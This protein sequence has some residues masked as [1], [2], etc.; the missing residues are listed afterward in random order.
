MIGRKYKKSIVAAGHIEVCEAA[1]VILEAG[2]NAFD[3]MVAAG[4]A[5]TVVEPALTSLGGGGFM[6][7]Y[8]AATKSELFFDFFVDTPGKGHRA[9]ELEPHFFPVT[10]NFS[11]ASQ[12][13]NVGMGSVAVP[14]T[15]KGLLHVHKRLGRMPLKTVIEPARKLA[16]GHELNSQQAHFLDLL[17]PIMTL[18]PAGR[19]LYESNGKY[20]QGGEQL[21]NSSLADFLESIV[22]EG[23][24][25]FYR[26]D[27]AQAIAEDM[28]N[29]DGLL[30]CD[31]LADYQVYERS[32]LKIHYRGAEFLTAPEPSVGGTLIGLS[33]SLAAESVVN[34]PDWGSAEYLKKV[35]ARMQEVER[36]REQGVTTPAALREYF[37]ASDISDRADSPRLFSRGTTHISIADC[38]GNCASMTCSNGEGSGYF[39]PGTGIMLN[40]MMG[41]D[42]LHPEGF[43][44]SPP[45]QRVQSMMSPSMLKKNE[46][47][48]L[49][50]GSGGSKRIRTAITQVLNQIVIDKRDVVDAVEAPRLYWDEDCLQVEPGF[51]DDAISELQKKEKVH[52]WKNKDVYFGGVHCVVPGIK[53]AG[54][55]RRGGA[56]LEV[57]NPT[58]RVE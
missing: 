28:R 35:T 5:S 7:G 30:T 38:N 48:E 42:D 11:G 43:H 8:S 6:L 34:E 10:V 54:D 1:S 40:N 55:S 18:M 4:F 51:T 53:G 31:D 26:G 50:I 49:V 41:E 12:D 44:S 20:V 36:L 2:G 23:D 57:K 45:G 37:A 21:V 25:S 47:I 14:G 52:I 39:A 27:I 58:K 19:K 22:F 32:P 9:E 24:A 56:V 13:F 17:K 3:A 15:L 16:L 29:G 46:D 33:L